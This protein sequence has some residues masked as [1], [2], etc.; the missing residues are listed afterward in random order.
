MPLDG[1]GHTCDR[2]VMA[3]RLLFAVLAVGLL[4]IAWAAWNGGQRIP[5][6]GA[7]VLAVWMGTMAAGGLRRRSR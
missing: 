7:L 3:T 5:A 4:V 6:I 2:A 1:S